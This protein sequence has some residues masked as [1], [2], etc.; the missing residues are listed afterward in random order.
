MGKYRFLKKTAVLAA[1]LK[2]LG[3]AVA[4]LTDSS[5]VAQQ[6]RKLLMSNLPE[7]PR[8]LKKLLVAGEVTFEV[9]P[10]VSAGDPLVIGETHYVISYRYNSEAKWR[11]SRDAQGARVLV[12]DA[13]FNRVRWKPRHVIWLRDKPAAGEFWSDSVL[14]HEFDHVRISTDPRVAKRFAE[15][16]RQ[17]RV[18]RHLLQ[19]GEVAGRELTDK[20]VERQARAVFDEL[21]ELI[22]IRYRELDR[23]TSHGR[24]PVPSDSKLYELLRPEAVSRT[25][26]EGR[27]VPDRK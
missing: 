9:G 12:I 16:L 27:D 5:V 20:L 22:A 4:L 19:P 10:R 21:T 26:G 23:E 13:G 3:F 18:I 2:V 1:A 7:P 8:Q 17:R 11:L 14:L 25:L 24:T 15:L 6:P